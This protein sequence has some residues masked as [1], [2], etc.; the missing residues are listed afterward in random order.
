M[1]LSC[2]RIGDAAKIFVFLSVFVCSVAF[3]FELRKDW[4]V[5]KN[6]FFFFSVFVCFVV[7]VC[8]FKLR[9]DWWGSKKNCIFSVFVFVF[10][11]ELRKDWWGST[12]ICIFLHIYMFVCFCICMCIWAE[13][14]ICFLSVFECLVVFV[15]A[16]VFELQRRNNSTLSFLSEHVGGRVGEVGGWTPLFVVHTFV[17]VC[18]CMFICYC[19]CIWASQGVMRQQK[20]LTFWF[21]FTGGRVGEVGGWTHLVVTHI[22]PWEG[23]VPVTQVLR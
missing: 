11:F 2:A 8:V 13:R 19:I 23:C 16:C 15:F 10:V 1:Y 14:N 4:R 20:R 12:N 22:A 17:F 6:I 9:K 3:V 21:S 18:I 5:S 7:F